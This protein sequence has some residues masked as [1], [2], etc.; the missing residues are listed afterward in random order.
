MRI[1]NSLRSNWILRRQ[2][3]DS[4]S[5]VN[6]RSAI[7]DIVELCSRLYKRSFTSFDNECRFTTLKGRRHYISVKSSDIL[8]NFFQMNNTSKSIYCLSWLIY[9]LK[10]EIFSAYVVHQFLD[11]FTLEYLLRQKSILSRWQWLHHTV[12]IKLKKI[13]RK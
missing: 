12:T 8:Q 2:N 9:L 7:R 10:N 4:P 11:H 6:L 13:F 1:C 3:L 5:R